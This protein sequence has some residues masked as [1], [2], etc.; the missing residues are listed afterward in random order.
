ML[1]RNRDGSIRVD[2]DRLVVMS[3]LAAIAAWG[4][5]AAVSAKAGL[6]LMLALDFVT[7][8]VGIVDG[9]GIW[10]RLW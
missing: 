5:S 2:T 4:T 6:W 1:K 10:L 7:F 3:V 8:P 9:V